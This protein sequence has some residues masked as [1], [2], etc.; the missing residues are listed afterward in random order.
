[1]KK[2]GRIWRVFVVA[3][4][5]GSVAPAWATGDAEALRLM[6]Q[7]RHSLPDVPLSLDASLRL[8]DSY[9]RPLKTVSA[10]A[11]L[12]RTDDGSVARYR[13]LDAFGS[14]RD[15]MSITLGGAQADFSYATGDPPES[16][17]L[18]DLFASIAG[19]GVSWM[20]LSFSFF[21][22]EHPRIIGSE[23]VANRWE[24]QIIALDCPPEYESG[25]SEVRLWVAPAYGAVVRGEAWR[26]GRAIKRF[27]VLAVR[28]LRQVYMIGDMEIRDFENGTRSRLKVGRLEMISPDYTPEQ[29]QELYAPVVW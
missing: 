16:A 4:C 11:Q 15:E 3:L 23:K 18:P 19:T 2:K 21:W 10:E 27:E 24:C 5:L 12:T 17:P 29:L 14:V 26:D 1:M 25:W 28:K 20:E 9:G 22:W 13:I 7:V 6:E 8:L